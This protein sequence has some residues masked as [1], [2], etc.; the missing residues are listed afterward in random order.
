MGEAV[1]LQ[2]NSTS[3]ASVLSLS[4]AFRPESQVWDLNNPT[5]PRGFGFRALGFRV[6]GLGLMGFRV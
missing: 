3:E 6:Q 5:A 1:L 4:L 2:R